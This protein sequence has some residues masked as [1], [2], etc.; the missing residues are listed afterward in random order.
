M[1]TFQACTDGSL[2]VNY[3]NKITTSI[4]SKTGKYCIYFSFSVF[5]FQD[6]FEKY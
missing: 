4:L 2:F 3:N 1:W 5:I 6:Y